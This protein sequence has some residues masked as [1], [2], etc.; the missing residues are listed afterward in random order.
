[1]AVSKETYHDRSVFPRWDVLDRRHI[2]VSVQRHKEPSMT[3]AHSPVTLIN[4]LTVKSGQQD[5][6]VKSLRCNTESIITT[7]KGW[8]ATQLIASHDGTKVVIYSQWESAAD[9]NAMRADTRMQAY[10][11]E[12][13]ALASL[14][15][16]WGT[17]VTAHERT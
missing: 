17:I 1:M 8:I 14:D 11:P 15:S 9:M 16:T 2:D 3:S 12:V 6:L 7:L 5:A 10:F 13:A 4:V